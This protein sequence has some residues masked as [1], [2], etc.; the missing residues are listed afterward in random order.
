MFYLQQKKEASTKANCG[1]HRGTHFATK[2]LDTVQGWGIYSKCG[3][4]W[5]NHGS[6]AEG[7]WQTAGRVGGI[8]QWGYYGV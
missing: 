2:G 1:G 3:T 4:D 7:T 8:I 6:T 5:Q